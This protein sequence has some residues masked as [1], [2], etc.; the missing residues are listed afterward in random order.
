VFGREAGWVGEILYLYLHRES[1]LGM[2]DEEVVTRGK[3]GIV[4]GVYGTGLV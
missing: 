3:I 1:D 4:D 2:G